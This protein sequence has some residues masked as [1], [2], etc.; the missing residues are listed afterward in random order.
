[1]RFAFV[2]TMCGVPWGG[3]EELWSRAASQL[4]REGNEIAASVVWWPRLARQVSDLAEQ[5]IAVSTQTRPRASLPL[6]I[7]RKIS[8]RIGIPRPEVSWLRQGKPD[9]VVISQGYNRDGLEWMKQCRELEIPYA[10]V[11]QCNSEIWWP[12]G[13]VSDEMAAAYRSAKGVFCVSRHNL[14][15][16][17]LQI[18]ESLPNASVVWNPF[19]VPSGEPPDWPAE[20]GPLKLAC[21]GRLDPAA[22]GQD[23]LLQVLAQPKWRERSVETNFYGAGMWEQSLRKLSGYLGAENVHFRGHSDN[24]R[25]IWEANHMLILPSRY[26][27]LPLA[28]IEAMWSARPAVVTDVGGNAEIC[29]DNETG[30]VTPAPAIDLLDQALERAWI[31]RDEWRTMGEAARRHVEMVVPKDPIAEFCGLLKKCLP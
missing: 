7:L 26:E 23:L 19:N 28:L 17:E 12:S 3:S 22:K 30:F 14:R 13:E 31:R 11:I 1:M 2:S 21:V 18:G 24:V 6:E 15:L 29:I 25:G 10:A 20:S 16:L 8:Y 5:G 4:R 9:L 27:G